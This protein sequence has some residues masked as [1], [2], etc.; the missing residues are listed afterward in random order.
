MNKKVI[1]ILFSILIILVILLMVIKYAFHHEN[2]K[3]IKNDIQNNISLN[4]FNEYN[5]V[6]N[7]NIENN[8]V[9]EENQGMNRK[10]DEI[11]IKLTVNN[12]TYTATLINN[13][14]TNE[15]VKMFPLTINMSD[16]NSNEKYYYLNTNLTTN[17]KKQ[18]IINIGDIKLFGNNCLVVFY[19][20]FNTSYSYTNL[21]RID[22]IEDF[23][24]EL[25]KDDVIIKFEL[26]N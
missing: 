19:K 24:S 3:Y 26:N 18:D 6:D 8:N 20:S 23:I 16:L 10:K 22:N 1:F 21:G 25:G 14:T 11:K 2:K 15:L 17:S 13:E 12:K 9:K 5:N 7:K 4:Y